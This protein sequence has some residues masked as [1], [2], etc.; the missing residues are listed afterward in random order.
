M[1]RHFLL[2]YHYT[3]SKKH[4]FLRFLFNH[5]VADILRLSN[6]SS[7]QSDIMDDSEDADLV[8]HP[9]E[10]LRRMTNCT[11]QVNPTI[12]INRYYRSL[13]ECY[14][15]AGFYLQSEEYERAFLLIMRFINT[16]IEELPKHI[17]YD[18]FT[19]PEKTKME[20][21]LPGAFEIAKKL[22]SRL[23]VTFEREAEQRRREIEQRAALLVA[24]QERAQ[25]ESQNRQKLDAGGSSILVNPEITTDHISYGKLVNNV[26]R[27]PQAVKPASTSSLRSAGEHKISIAA[28][29]V[30]KFI[31]AAEANSAKNIETCAILCGTPAKGGSYLITHAVIPKQKGAPD[32][33]DTLCEEEVFAYQD[34]HKL[35]TLGWIHT[36]PSQTAFMSSVDIHTQCGYQLM[37]PE[38]IALV[39][40]I[41]DKNLGVF[42]LTEFGLKEVSQCSERGFHSHEKVPPLYISCDEDLSTVNSLDAVVV[43]LRN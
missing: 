30:S 32:T 26:T 34:A 37:L 21:Y 40:S 5:L 2:A 33:C 24:E 10:R 43:D 27:V 28:N 29:I 11:I 38:S 16:M 15:V 19:S 9:E 4:Y 42:R 35:I 12:P 25:R 20:T 22:K 36:H 3:Y 6:A 13:G 39:A 41:K 7:F 31:K 1:R 14:R 17:E 23:K 18:G 8:L